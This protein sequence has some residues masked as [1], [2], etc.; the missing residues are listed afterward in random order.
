M[1]FYSV[2]ARQS[3]S[4]FFDKVFDAGSHDQRTL[5]KKTLTKLLMENFDWTFRV[6]QP[7]VTSTSIHN[8][9]GNN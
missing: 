3:P 2:Q 8:R 1:G 6:L 9:I 5:L 7:I 4:K